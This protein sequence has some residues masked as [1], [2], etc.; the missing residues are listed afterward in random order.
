MGLE[1]MKGAFAAPTD[2]TTINPLLNAFTDM[3]KSV[4]SPVLL[5]LIGALFT[6]LTQSSSATSGIV[7]VMVGGGAIPLDSGFYLVLGATI[8][9]VL[10]TIIASIGGEVGAKRT[11]YL[12]L[13]F[14]SKYL[15]IL[16]MSFLSR[17]GSTT[18]DLFFIVFT[19]L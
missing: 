4:N 15:I 3:F 5:L 12:C 10:V 13:L 1:L 11:A 16:W 2:G 14:S 18:F 19:L 7:I 17:I 6:C 9:T 8:G